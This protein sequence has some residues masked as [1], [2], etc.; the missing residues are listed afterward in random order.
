[1][2]KSAGFLQLSLGIET[3]DENQMA[4]HKPGVHLEGVRDTVRRIQ[5][6]GLRAKGLFM[7]GLPGETVASIQKT[8]AFTL[9]LGLDDMNMSKFTPFHGAPLWA[10]IRDQGSL[11]EDWRKMNCLNFVFIPGSIDSRETLEQLYNQHVKGFYTDPAW[12][13]RFRSRLWE[14]RR[15][16]FYFVRHLPSFLSARRNFEPGD[17]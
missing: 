1:M 2:L 5:A 10:S 16:L 12:R 8:T 14:H 7:M 4:V 17:P 13:R 11:D 9:S 15:S 3:G 6:K